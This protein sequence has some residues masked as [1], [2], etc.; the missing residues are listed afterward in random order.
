MLVDGVNDDEASVTDVAAFLE[1]IHPRV[2]YIALPIRPPAVPGVRPA[3]E[4]A[5]TRAYHIF[6][7]RSF[8]VEL[9]TGYEEST[10]AHTGDAEADLLGIT[11]V[12]PMR[13]ESVRALLTANGAHW[14]LVE[15]LMAR[16]ELKE[17]A[18]QGHRFYVR[19]IPR[20]D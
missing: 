14:D 12:H 9:L 4:E 19:R 3:S 1:T 7:G 8:K 2:A 18:Y 15:S 17:V 20:R 10:F 16:G 11:T 5:V 13:E 6:S